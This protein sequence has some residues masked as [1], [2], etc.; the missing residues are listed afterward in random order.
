MPH[1]IRR[2]ELCHILNDR[3]AE[4]LRLILL[5]VRESGLEL[6]PHAGVVFTGGGAS[7]A[8]WADLAKEVFHAP[9]RIAVPKDILGL[10]EN[11]KDPT[12]STSVGILLWGIHH[13]TEQ[14]AYHQKNGR[15]PSWRGRWWL[16]WLGQVMESKGK[17]SRRRQQ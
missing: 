4:L 6:M 5:K 15:G 1:L 13:P 17:S 3:G 10:P 7:L 11:L 9:V 12:Y 14:L 16:R 2:R 8:G